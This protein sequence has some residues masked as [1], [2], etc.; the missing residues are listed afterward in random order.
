MSDHAGGVP[1]VPGSL[2]VEQE[3][4]GPRVLWLRGDVDSATVARFQVEQGRAPVVVDV[5]DAGEVSF[6]C[7]AAI[8][9][10]ILAV[11]A[12][13]GAGRRPVLRA[14]SRPVDRV[15]M[16]SGMSDVFPRQG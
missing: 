8:A 9:V 16:L 1:P 10:M 14:A 15:L 3:P 6:I 4:A 5:I 13:A 12:S 11:E 7:S 2:V